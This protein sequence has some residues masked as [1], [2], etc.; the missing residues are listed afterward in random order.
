MTAVLFV[1]VS[2]VPLVP[3]DDCCV[4]RTSVCR[5][6]G[7][8]PHGV[9]DGCCVVRTIV[10]RPLGVQPTVFLMA[11]VLFVPVSAA[12]LVPGRSR[13][14]VR[15]APAFPVGLTRLGITVRGQIPLL[16]GKGASVGDMVV[17]LD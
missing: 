7:A 6:L 16:S 2:A 8:Q 15:M 10:C 9:P 14:V 13:P 1:P 4:V 3:P 11:A 5:P 17:I 12:P